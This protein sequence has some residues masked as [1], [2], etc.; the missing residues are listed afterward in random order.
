MIKKQEEVAVFVGRGMTIEAA[1]EEHSQQWF[2][3][4]EAGK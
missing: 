2:E 3:L 4:Q 1:I